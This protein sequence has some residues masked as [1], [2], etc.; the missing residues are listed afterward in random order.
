MCPHGRSRGRS[1]S[2][3]QQ[4]LLHRELPGP[5]RVPSP[6]GRVIPS[7]PPWP[8]LPE[9]RGEQGSGGRPGRILDG[10]PSLHSHSHVGLWTD[11]GGDGDLTLLLPPGSCR[12]RPSPPVG[13]GTGLA[14]RADLSCHRHTTDGASIR[15]LAQ[16]E[17]TTT[18][19]GDMGS[20]TART[21]QTTARRVGWMDRQSSPACMPLTVYFC[22]AGAVL[23][24][25]PGIPSGALL[26]GL[27][28][29]QPVLGD[30]AGIAWPHQV[31]A[32]AAQV[33]TVVL[34]WGKGTWPSELSPALGGCQP[35][36]PAPSHCIPEP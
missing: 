30:G 35:S 26:P 14:G 36:L 15:D 32:L 13:R 29:V 22:L 20:W 28:A 10:H 18:T 1:R 3:S 11:P 2:L 7:A 27:G 21:A 31:H 16:T 12:H 4:H 25:A 8:G 9:P 24:V 6:E 17:G 34:V 19:F 5:E 23:L 33:D